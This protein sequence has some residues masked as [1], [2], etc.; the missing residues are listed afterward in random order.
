VAEGWTA[1]A[2]VDRATFRPTRVPAWL[3][4]ALATGSEEP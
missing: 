3:V 1:H 2:C 4:E